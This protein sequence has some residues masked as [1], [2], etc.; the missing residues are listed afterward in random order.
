MPKKETSQML[1]EI[2]EQPIVLKNVAKKHFQEQGIVFPEFGKQLN[3]FQKAKRFIFLGC[4][5]SYHASFLGNYFFEELAEVNSEV[6]LADEFNVRRAVI[7]KKTVVVILSQ[8][9]ETGE[10]LQAAGLVKKKKALLVAITNNPKSSLAKLVDVHI[11]CQAGEEKALAATKSFTTQVLC[12]L[13]LSLYKKQISKSKKTKVK[14]DFFK[15][16]KFLPGKVEKIL[17][18]AGEIKAI[19]WKYKRLEKLMVLGDRLSYPIALE[20]ALKLKE[21]TYISAEGLATGELRHGPLALVD[22]NFL[23]IVFAPMDSVYKNGISAIRD[24][25]S[26]K[27]EVIAI[28]SRGKE[29]VKADNTVFI[30]RA[31]EF[32]NPI[33]EIISIQ[34][35]AYYVAK[36]KKLDVDKPRNLKKFV[37]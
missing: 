3:R 36:Y 30:P 28:T 17:G 34:L 13:L 10:A 6:E 18:Q 16:I 9:G 5:T 25:K 35:L 33:L 14:E 12:L 8:S 24:I 21:T 1:A 32:L 22:K 2:F 15:E 19:A 20:S 27:G 31:S 37:K 7:D 23:A 4:G 29:A 26:A 11:D